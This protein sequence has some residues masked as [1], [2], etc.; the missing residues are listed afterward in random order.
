MDLLHSKEQE[1]A[2]EV[3]ESYENSKPFFDIDLKD[4]FFIIPS[5]NMMYLEDKIEKLN[6]KAIKIG[7]DPIVIKQSAQIVRKEWRKYRS[8]YEGWKSN[9]QSK[10]VEKFYKLVEIVGEAPVINGWKLAAVLEHLDGTE[11]TLVKTVPGETVPDKY[12]T[13]GRYLCEHC[14]RNINRKNTF[15]VYNE[16]SV[17]YKAVG[18][19]CIK[20]FLGH[21]DPKLFAQW[22]SWLDRFYKDVKEF[23][24]E[25]YD[26]PKSVGRKPIPNIGLTDFMGYVCESIIRHGWIS[27]KKYQESLDWEGHSNLTPTTWDAEENFFKRNPKD[28][29]YW[30]PSEEALERSENIMEWAPKFH[31]MVNDGDYFHNLSTI[32]KAGFVDRRSYGLAAS[33]SPW[34]WREIEAKAEDKAK[35][36]DAP[37]SQHVGNVK[38]RLQFDVNIIFMKE[39]ERQSYSYYDSGISYLYKMI[40][41]EGNHLTWFASKDEMEVEKDY[42]IL[43]TVKKH[44]T[45]NGVKQ[46]LLNRCKVM[47]ELV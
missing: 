45:Y 29:D 39:I 2:R 7:S 23:Q 9:T 27:K 1:W 33:M 42:R 4:G 17:D 6:K 36:P 34:Y 10:P 16:D 12:R 20:D 47:E 11:E 5:H 40:D 22:A 8:L 15:V 43:G 26:G 31:D 37:E 14:H 38:D 21:T 30:D 19:G 32:L 28:N 25:D 18:S 13:I 44:D 46:T 3:K 24:D 41:T 35:K